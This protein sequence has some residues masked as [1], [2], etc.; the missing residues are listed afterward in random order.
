MNFIE[1]LK[2]LL[3]LGIFIPEKIVDLIESTGI[4]TIAVF[5][6]YLMNQCIVKQL[7]SLTNFNKEKAASKV[8]NELIEGD[9]S[10][11]FT[12]LIILST[13]GIAHLLLIPIKNCKKTRPTTKKKVILK[14]IGTGLWNL[15]NLTV[16]IRIILQYFQSL[17]ITAASRLNKVDF[18]TDESVM[19]YTLAA[20]LQAS[21][22]GIFIFG[23]FLWSYYKKSKEI[24]CTSLFAEF[25][26]KQNK[27]K[28]AFLYNSLFMSR[29]L[30]F[31]IW[32]FSFMGM[33]KFSYVLILV[34][35]QISHAMLI[36]LV[37]P[38]NNVKDNI[39]ELI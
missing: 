31:A 18:S 21:C 28:M 13:L 5:L 22:V 14:S 17:T 39:V 1:L 16:Y 6:P 26:V 36:L 38:F 12:V 2:Y 8:T 29:R 25:F 11:F 27:T 10:N 30:F 34:L 23:L 37:R 24:S 19:F 3:L 32:I 4:I 35:Y 9:F 20:L 15:F 7:L 33:S